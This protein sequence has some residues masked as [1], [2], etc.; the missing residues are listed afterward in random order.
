MSVCNP[1]LPHV[2]LC[3][4]DLNCLLAPLLVAFSQP[5]ISLLLRPYVLS[6]KKSWLLDHSQKRAS[7]QEDYGIDVVSTG[8]FLTSMA[9]GKW[10][11]NE[12]YLQRQTC[13]QPT[14]EWMRFVPLDTP[15]TNGAK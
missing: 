4:A 10:H 12:P 14:D 13:R 2:W 3:S 5:L 11:A 6:F 7:Q 8:R 9:H 15:G 1:L